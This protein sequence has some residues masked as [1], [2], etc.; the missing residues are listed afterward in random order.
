M[1]PKILAT[2]NVSDLSNEK[3]LFSRQVIPK[4]PQALDERPSLTSILPLVIWLWAAAS[5]ILGRSFTAVLPDPRDAQLFAYVGL[6]WTHGHIPYLSIWDNKP[7]GIFAIDAM[8][9]SVFPKSF[10]ALAVMEGVFVFGCVATVYFLLKQWGLLL[11][12]R[13]SRQVLPRSLAIWTCLIN[14][15]IGQKCTS[16]GRPP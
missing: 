9:F 7:P 14:M 5:T 15:E 16:S 1:S 13:R 8:V 11:K 12:S 10:T 2:R 3:L 4:L 6:Q